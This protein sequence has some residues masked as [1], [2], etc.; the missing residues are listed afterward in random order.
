MKRLEG[1]E[2]LSWGE[3]EGKDSKLEPSKGQLAEL[4]RAWD[5]GIFDRCENMAAGGWKLLD[6]IDHPLTSLFVLGSNF[7]YFQK[8]SRGPMYCCAHSA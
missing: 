5:D 4:K 2:E 1:L 7:T 8:R 3:L 6:R